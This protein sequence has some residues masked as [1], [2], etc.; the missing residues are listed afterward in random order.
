MEWGPQAAQTALLAGP[1]YTGQVRG[2]GENMQKEEPEGWG[3]SLFSSF[4]SACP[5]ALRMYF[6]YFLNKTEL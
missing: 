5:H 6:L 3:L 1:G 4:R 2:G